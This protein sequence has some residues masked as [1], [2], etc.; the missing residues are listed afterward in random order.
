MTTKNNEE[1]KHHEEKA[2]RRTCSCD[3]FVKKKNTI[4]F[5]NN[6]KDGGSERLIFLYQPSWSAMDSKS[7]KKKRT[8]W[9]VLEAAAALLSLVELAKKMMVGFEWMYIIKS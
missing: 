1:K 6:I 3:V 7:N 9:Y 2:D 4:M 8:K 5:Y